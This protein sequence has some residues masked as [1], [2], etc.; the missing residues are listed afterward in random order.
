[1]RAGGGGVRNIRR[2]D[3]LG[4][5]ILGRFGLVSKMF[6]FRN[7]FLALWQTGQYSRKITEETRKQEKC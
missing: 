3:Q 2:E 1:M 4:E 5:A 6:Q 7:N